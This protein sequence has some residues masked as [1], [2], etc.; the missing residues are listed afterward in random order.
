M[1]Y[2]LYQ[3]QSDMLLP[4]RTMAQAMQ[5]T[6]GWTHRAPRLPMMRRMS[7]ALELFDR[8]QLTHDRPDFRIRQVKT[9]GRIVDVFEKVVTATPFGALLHFRKDMDARHPAVLVV[10]PLSGHFSTLLRNTVETLLQDHDVYITDWHN[11]RDVPVSAGEFGFA[12]YIDSV[13]SFLEYVG[14]GAHVVAVCQPCVQ[15]LAA[16][17]LMAADDHP[18]QPKSMTLMGGPIDVRQSPATV[19]ALAFDH[20]IEW[21]EKNLITTVPLRYRGAGRRV[22][23]GF[24][25]LN[26]FMKMN[27]ARHVKAHRKLYKHLANNEHEEAAAI[28]EFYDE[29]FAVLDMP[30]E[31][32]LETVRLVFQEALLAKG[33]LTHRGER[34]D[35]SK[36]KRTALLTVEGER[37]DVCA[38]GQTA[39]AHDLCTGLRP[40][41]KRHHMQVG[42]GHYGLFSGKRWETQIYP[43]VRNTILS[44]S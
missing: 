27:M 20:P 28:K 29:Y 42:V 38:L 26:A 8:F 7:A 40:Y 9:G 11:A 6:F 5:A 14:P 30:A 24:V 39:A 21:F 32:Y 35:P 16:V 2:Q 18:C 43:L 25:Q 3:T 36:I 41:M 37:D 44:S 33:K 31:F 10:A 15:V 34:V 17:A 22:Y 13:I 1:L 4:M 12:D 19:N 23:P